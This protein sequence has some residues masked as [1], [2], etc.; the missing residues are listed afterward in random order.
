MTVKTSATIAP[1][2]QAEEGIA[3]GKGIDEI[4][5]AIEVAGVDQTADAQHHQHNDWRSRS[6]TLARGLETS[7]TASAARLR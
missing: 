3:V 6:I 2:G 4:I 7:S 1:Q 5:G